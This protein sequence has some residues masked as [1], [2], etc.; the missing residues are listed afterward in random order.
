MWDAQPKA[1]S[2]FESFCHVI[3]GLALITW[4]ASWMLVSNIPSDPEAADPSVVSSRL[5]AMDVPF[6]ESIP[7]DYGVRVPA[8]KTI[9][10][11]QTDS[12]ECDQWIDFE[13]DEFEHAGYR[14][15]VCEPTTHKYRDGLNFLV[16]DGESNSELTGY[17]TVAMVRDLN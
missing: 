4:L 9:V 14:V 6:M 17:I 16:R 7:V 10:L 12:K 8:V 3:V 2:L 5:A 15:V 11:F 1:P 13:K